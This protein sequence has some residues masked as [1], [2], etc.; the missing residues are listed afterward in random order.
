MHDFPTDHGNLLRFT[1]EADKALEDQR[2]NLVTEVTAEVWKR[3][4]QGHDL[5]TEL[6]LHALHSED[7]TQQH[8]Q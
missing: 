7:V 8:S 2:A 6:S 1:L 4:E 3:Y 5:P